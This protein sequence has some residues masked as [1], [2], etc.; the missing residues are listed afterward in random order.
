MFFQLFSYGK[1]TVKNSVNTL[2]D[3]N[4]PEGVRL[5]KVVTILSTLQGSCLNTGTTAASLKQ[6]RIARSAQQ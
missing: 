4:E 6:Q 5:S 3:G 2:F 1:K